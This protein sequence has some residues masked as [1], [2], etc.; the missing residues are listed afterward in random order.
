MVHVSNISTCNSIY[1]PYCHSVI[2]YGIIMWGNSSNSG[3]I[4][5]LQKKIIRI[6]A[7]TH[8]RTSYRSLFKQVK[9]VPFS[10]QYI[11]L[12]M[13]F[14]FSNQNIFQTISS[15]HSINTRNPYQLR[16][17]NA[18]LSCFQKSIF[19]TG[20]K[21]F[22]NLPVSVTILKKDKAQFKAASRKYQHAHSFLLFI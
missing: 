18:N 5:I 1:Y 15:V 21:I 3:K 13:N 6:V 20:I 10:Y 12:L 8:C 22:N 19:Y 14:F 11:L 2:K 16:R 9:I 17:P 4:F 7:G